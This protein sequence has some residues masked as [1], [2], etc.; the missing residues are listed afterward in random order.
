[1]LEIFKKIGNKKSILS[2]GIDK[3]IMLAL[4][5]LLLVTGTAF[6]PDNKNTGKNFSDK[7][8][9]VINEREDNEYVAGMEKELTDILESIKGVGKVKVMITVGDD[10]KQIVLREEPYSKS[11]EVS[12]GDEGDKIIR[13]DISKEDR[14]VLGSGEDGENSPYIIS[15]QKPEVQGVAVVAEGGGNPLV[16]E[17]ITKVI[18]S[19]FEVSVHKISVI[20]M[21]G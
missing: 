11:S 5:G 17:K 2:I 19:L 14:V 10:G 13:E 8:E 18:K 7:N 21:K 6:F 1:M 12:E 20:E 9:G 4:A 15:S 3:W 16:V